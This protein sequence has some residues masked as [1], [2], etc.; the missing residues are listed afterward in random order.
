MLEIKYALV[1]L[2]EEAL[3]RIESFYQVY[4]VNR[5]EL[6]LFR[7][8]EVSLEPKEEIELRQVEVSQLSEG[9]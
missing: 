5:V 4:Y 9:I 1:H 6:Q 7:N 2:S 8:R 3:S